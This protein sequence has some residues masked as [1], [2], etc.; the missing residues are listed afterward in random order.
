MPKIVKHVNGV[1][2]VI[3]RVYV[4]ILKKWKENSTPTESTTQTV[5]NPTDA[6]TLIVLNERELDITTMI[7]PIDVIFK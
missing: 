6:S 7:V 1:K 4:E 5:G 3:L 2:V